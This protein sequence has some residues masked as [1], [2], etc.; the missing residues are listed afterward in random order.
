MSKQ[1]NIINTS[2]TKV[3]LDIKK[4][5]KRKKNDT[6]I[7]LDMSKLNTNKKMKMDGPL[8]KTN[9]GL[10]Q[11]KK[12]KGRN[13][14]TEEKMMRMMDSPKK[15]Y[16]ITPTEEETET[17]LKQT[18]QDSDTE[19]KDTDVEAVTK[20]VRFEIRQE[21]N[22][23]IHFSMDN[24]LD[25]KNRE[26]LVKEML[27][28]I[29]DVE[30]KLVMCSEMKDLEKKREFFNNCL[31]TRKDII[32]VDDFMMSCAKEELTTSLMSLNIEEMVTVKGI[33]E[34]KIEDGIDSIREYNRGMTNNCN[35]IDCKVKNKASNGISN[36]V[37][38]LSNSEVKKETL[39][40]ASIKMTMSLKCRDVSVVVSSNKEKEKMVSVYRIK[41]NMKL[42]DLRFTDIKQTGFPSTNYDFS[43]H[44]MIDLKH[45]MTDMD[46]K[47]TY[48]SF[49]LVS[50]MRSQDDN[51]IG[52]KEM[53]DMSDNNSEKEEE[54]P[55]GDCF[56]KFLARVFGTEINLESYEDKFYCVNDMPAWMEMYYL[57]SIKKRNIYIRTNGSS[58]SANHISFLRFRESIK[59]KGYMLSS[60]QLRNTNF[61]MDDTAFV[62]ETTQ[63]ALKIMIRKKRVRMVDSTIR[64]MCL[65][66]N[67]SDRNM[68]IFMFFNYRSLDELLE[69]MSKMSMLEMNSLYERY[70][71]KINLCKESLKESLDSIIPSLMGNMKFKSMEFSVTD[72]IELMSRMLFHKDGSA[73][74]TL[75][76]HFNNELLLFQLF[77]MAD[78]LKEL[79]DCVIEFGMTS[80]ASKAMEK[81]SS[82]LA[83][84][85][86]L[87]KVGDDNLD[88]ELYKKKVI[89]PINQDRKTYNIMEDLKRE[90]TEES[91]DNSNNM[92]MEMDEDVDY[93]EENF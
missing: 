43:K 55:D 67:I 19:V 78:N 48:S 86:L 84:M 70:L 91:E 62:D 49:L 88:L 85:D 28:K 68:L 31:E 38:R 46:M 20:A 21:D 8:K 6:R 75:R 37:N 32:M 61:Y 7:Y 50:F 69:D 80:V 33:E 79:S 36:L 47:V 42:F 59:I 45:Y 14:T 76:D 34:L 27:K 30:R 81:I 60:L 54:I 82:S 5:N 9:I 72:I 3:N 77:S 44:T 89:G 41:D 35:C 39:L 29:K 63:K 24:K 2:Y 1:I 53:K 58:D 4:N 71:F 65:D 18:I 93:P 10:D 64:K 16:V 74:L 87:K 26:S 23:D 25:L 15:M 90:M 13:M 17:I 92:L 40:T 57:M 83:I 73:W 66:K 11:I 52:L 22:K 51:L 12:H 56:T